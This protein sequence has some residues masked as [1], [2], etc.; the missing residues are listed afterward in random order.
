MKM[1]FLTEDQLEELIYEYRNDIHERGLPKFYTNTI[2][3]FV[4]PNKKVIDLFTYE[5][6]DNE[7][8][9]RIIELKKDFIWVDAFIQIIGYFATVKAL[10]DTKFSNIHYDLV[11]AGEG[12]NVI[13][14]A[15]LN[16]F[17]GNVKVYTYDLTYEGIRFTE[18]IYEP[19][20]S[21]KSLELY[22]YLLN[23]SIDEFG[24]DM[25]IR[26]LDISNTLT[27]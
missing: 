8:Y 20:E 4:L 23:P 27:S 22:S 7:L 25:R 10:S 2:R 14:L 9:F 6:I 21:N 18:Q 1:K 5:I 3:Q 11:L 12:I 24:F 15:V 19:K 16:L 17:H 26:T 13:P